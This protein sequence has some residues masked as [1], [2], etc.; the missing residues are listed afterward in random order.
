MSKP[1]GNWEDDFNRGDT[2]R[3]VRAAPHTSR[4]EP[5]IDRLRRIC[6][7]KQ[8][9]RVDGVLVDMTSASVTVQVHDA[10]NEANRAKLA[11]MPVRKM[12]MVA[13][14]VASKS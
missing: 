2:A 7:E 9:A 13:L 4:K 1:T 14:S 3:F 10:L 12:V 6:E 5:V 8:A 11:A